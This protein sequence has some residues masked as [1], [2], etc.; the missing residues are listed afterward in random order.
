MLFAYSNVVLMSMEIAICNR[1]AIACPIII[2]HAT[3][4]K[5]RISMYERILYLLLKISVNF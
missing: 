2:M 1:I 3:S 4:T 5:S